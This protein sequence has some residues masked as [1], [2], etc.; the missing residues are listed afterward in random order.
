MV[1]AQDGIIGPQ[2]GHM[3]GSLFDIAAG[4]VATATG[5]E[6]ADLLTED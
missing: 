5:G 6:S 1:E 2:I 4:N 3:T